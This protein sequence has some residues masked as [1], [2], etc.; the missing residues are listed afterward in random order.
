M[1]IYK[2]TTSRRCLS[3]VWRSPFL[4]GK[5]GNP[6]ILSIILVCEILI[7]ISY[8]FSE[9][10]IAT[11]DNYFFSRSVNVKPLTRLSTLIRARRISPCEE[12]V[13]HKI[14][15]SSAQG[16]SPRPRLL[17]VPEALYPHF[18]PESG[19]FQWSWCGRTG[20]DSGNTEAITTSRDSFIEVVNL[21]VSLLMTPTSC[22]GTACLVLLKFAMYKS[23][24]IL[25]F[26]KPSQ[27]R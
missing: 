10:A 3:E 15:R 13:V 23:K 8:F 9:C 4:I 5:P 21:P 7:E 18:S 2:F 27:M 1:T 14:S 22:L 25:P 17:H 19:Q 24:V 11:W 6:C 16:H 20:W 12:E 26:E